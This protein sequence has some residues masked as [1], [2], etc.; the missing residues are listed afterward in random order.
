MAYA[1]AAAPTAAVFAEGVRGLKRKTENREEEE[2]EEEEEEREDDDGGYVDD[3]EEEEEEEE[4]EDEGKGGPAAA[5]SGG[6]VTRVQQ[7]LGFDES[8]IY[9][10][11]RACQ[12]VWRAEAN[13]NYYAHRRLHKRFCTDLDDGRGD[14]GPAY[15]TAIAKC[16]EKLDEPLPEPSNPFKLRD[17]AASEGVRRL[18]DV[19]MWMETLAAI[20]GD[21][22]PLPEL[23][24]QIAW[25]WLKCCLPSIVGEEEWVTSQAL[26]LEMLE[27]EERKS[28]GAVLTPRQNGKSRTTGYMLAIFLLVVPKL[29]IACFASQGSQAKEVQSYTL[30]FL[31][32]A[33]FEAQISTNSTNGTLT[34]HHDE[35]D[36]ILTAYPMNPYVYR[37]FVSSSSLHGAHAHK[38]KHTSTHAFE[39]AKKGFYRTTRQGTLV[40]YKC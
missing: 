18:N 35:G 23:Q 6:G 32:E 5:A 36:S 28:M 1:A 37:L 4:E 3:D 2:E 14:Y 17:D 27:I 31:I 9:A 30:R 7:D 11:A 39:E 20:T 21:G 40:W 12:F 33:G 34:F 8:A 25:L 19:L 13:T 10:G 38:H 26:F 22:K 24:R 16:L 29:K 15:H